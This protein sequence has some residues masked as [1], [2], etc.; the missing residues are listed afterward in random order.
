[1]DIMEPCEASK[2][3]F[4]LPSVYGLFCCFACHSFILSSKM[5]L[6]PLTSS[7]FFECILQI[8]WYLSL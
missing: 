4:L 1:M 5:W 2:D 6:N 8:Q 3:Y 7:Y